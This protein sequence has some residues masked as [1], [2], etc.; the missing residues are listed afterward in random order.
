MVCGFIQYDSNM[1]LYLNGK[2]AR[3]ITAVDN[4]RGSLDFYKSPCWTHG[5]VI[6]NK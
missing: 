3:I 5:S 2:T 1:T 6:F 4:T